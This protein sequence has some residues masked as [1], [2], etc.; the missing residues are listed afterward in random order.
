MG[1]AFVVFVAGGVAG[2]LLGF[3]PK[4]LWFFVGASS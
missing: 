2:D 3:D 4:L 1:S